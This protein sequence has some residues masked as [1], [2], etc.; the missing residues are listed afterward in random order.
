[1]AFK[2]PSI[3][4]FREAG[5]GKV[6]NVKGFYQFF[7]QD[8]ELGHK[9]EKY[10]EIYK[11]VPI[12]QA[13]I[14]YT[15]DLAVGTG[16]K[17][18]SEDEKAKA[19]VAEVLE[20]QDFGL[21]SHRLIRH[22]LV[23][24][25]AYVEIVKLGD[26]LVDLKLLHPKNMVVDTD[27]TGEVK[28]YRQELGQGKTINFTSEEIAHF[29]W[30][31]IGDEIYGTSAIESVV[32]ALNTKL[33]MESD[34]RII[35]HRYAAPQIQYA[36]GTDAEPTTEDQITEFESQLDNQTPEMDLVTS[37]VVK[38]N[39]IRPLSGS[40]GVEEFL[41]HM[42]NQVI[43]GLQVPEVALGRGQNSTEATAKVQ[44][45][46]FDRR[47]KAI[48]RVL[49]RQTERL[50][51]EPMVGDDV[52]EIEFGEFEKEDEDVKVN[53]LLRLK[54]AGIVTADY[55][56]N[57]LDINKKFIPKETEEKPSNIS[58]V[59]GVDDSKKDVNPKKMPMKEGI[60][61]INKSGD[62]QELNT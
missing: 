13:A 38:V 11:K 45:G 26:K 53:R 18:I 2:L 44:L 27:D 19:E 5:K 8:Q 61:Y 49:T 12:V 15:A 43:A 35:S 30:N 41:K 60:Y 22:L 42:E 52:V 48:Q 59:K 58:N 55:V 62:I 46:I 34:L 16:Y 28:G 4:L 32:E 25:N 31:V 50:I 47:V 24:G 39:T 23:Y 20:Q 3:R 6:G 14:N 51:I 9:L 40:I 7:N 37:H 57:Q 17:L 10:E 33:Q 56:A 54:S 21:L 36:I 1:M 29:K